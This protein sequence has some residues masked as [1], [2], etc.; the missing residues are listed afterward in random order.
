MAQRPS[1][2]RGRRLRFG[3]IL[4]ALAFVIS[5]STL[6]ALYTDLLWYREVGF[7]SVF[8]TILGSRVLLAAAFGVAFFLF[9]LANLVI[10]GRLTPPWSL[11]VGPED[12]FERYRGAFVPYLRVFALVGSAVL[13]LLFALG[14]APLWEGF[15]LARNA[16]PF[17]AD[18]PVFG[19]DLG[20]FVF[21]LPV[22]RYLYSWAFSSLFVVTLI[23]AG[24]HYLTGGIRPQSPAGRVTPQVKAHLSVLIGL[25]ALLRAWG[26]RLDQFELMYST[27]GDITGASYTDLHAQLPALRLLVVISIIGAVLFL[28]NIRFRGWALPLAGLG[29]WLLTSVLAGGVFPYVIQRFRVEPAQLQR[30]RPYIKRNIEATRAAYGLEAMK[31]QEYPAKS[32]LTADLVAQNQGT[33]DNVRLW[34][35]ETLKAAYTQLQA[36]RPYYQFRDVDV[37]RYRIDGRLQ[38]VMLSARELDLANLG[39]QTWLNEHLVFTHGYGAVVSP[40]NEIAGEGRPEIL[41]RDVPPTSEVPGLE[42]TQGGVYFGEVLAPGAY[43]VVKT[44]QRELDFALADRTQ[45]TRYAGRAGVQMS[46]PLRRLAFAWRFRDVNLLV[47]GLI[48]PDSKIVYYRQVR[49]RLQ[50]AAPFLRFDGDPYLVITGGR[51]TWMVDAYTVSRMYPYSERFNLGA[52]T[53][54]RGDPLQEPSIRGEYNYI[55]NSVKVV[56]DAYDGTTTFY[57][58]DETDPII[59]AW[60]KAFPAL[61]QDAS[62]MPPEIREHVRYPEDLFRIQAGVYQRYH[63]IDP[64]D[65]YT[66]EDIW[67]IPSDPAEGQQPLNDELQ[68]YYVVMRLPGAAQE[69]YVLILPMNP[70]NRPNMVSWLAA[71]SGPEDYGELIDFRFPRGDQVDGVGQ[72]HSRINVDPKISQTRTLLG[73]PGAGS[74]VVFGNLLVFP[75]GT[76]ILYA[77]PMFLRAEANPIPELKFV[78]LA[79]RERVVMEPTLEQALKVLLEGGPVTA[80]SIGAPSRTKDELAKEAF[81]HL[82]NAEEA[83]R[84]GDWA[85]YGREQEA[86]REALRRAVEEGGGRPSPSPSPSPSR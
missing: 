46:G 59:R 6:T 15:V 73:Q 18:D 52:R 19:R 5:I 83:A 75:I 2:P 49:E 50:K 60:R 10:A 24:A 86:A 38:Q 35:T 70:K 66:R 55:R 40:T 74:E 3:L 20:F 82:L 14:I 48:R 62:K 58:W 34:D 1:R 80:P 65:F 68:P 21:R 78:I 77:Q 79:T 9:S 29:L 56:L 81:Q 36:I 67:V 84:R 41:V 16:V 11:V 13:A 22:Y 12:P 45:T 31:V 72:I 39:T 7:S 32:A 26:Y 8:W 44:R 25:I 28:V 63:M 43:S 47:S 4:A 27:R 54:L 33:I 51:L 37:D 64:V 42:I 71:K 30:E 23:V 17:G 85:A 57:V 61:F 53:F 69:E 76:S